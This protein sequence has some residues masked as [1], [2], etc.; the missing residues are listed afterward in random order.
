MA[1]DLNRLRLEQTEKA[2]APF[3]PLRGTPVP[4]DGWLRAVRESL[5]RSLRTQ[6]ERLGIS[7]SSL[8]KSEMAE[9]QGRTTLAQLRKMAEGLDCELVYALV[10]RQPLSKIVEEQADK[11]ARHEVLGVAHSMSL[12]EQRP[13]NEFVERQIAQRRSAL[14]AGPWSKLWR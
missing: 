4:A 10:P 5:G 6:A 3:T 8:H 14:L 9:A 13:S 7:P 1:N 2:L 12:E 11:M